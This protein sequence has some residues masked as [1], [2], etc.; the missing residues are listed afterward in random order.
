[1]GVRAHVLTTDVTQQLDLDTTTHVH[2]YTPVCLDAFGGP[3]C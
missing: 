1:V 2:K 3:A